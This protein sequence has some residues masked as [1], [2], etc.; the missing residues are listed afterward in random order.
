MSEV[1]DT[2]DFKSW[3]IVQLMGHVKYAGHAEA[4]TLFGRS[5]IY[6]TVPQLTDSEGSLVKEGFVKIISPD[7]LY[8]ITPVTEA[9]AREMAKYLEK[10]PIEGYQHQFV[11]NTLVEQKLEAI[12]AKAAQ[13]VL[14]EAGF[15][16]KDL[17]KNPILR[18][19]EE[20]DWGTDRNPSKV[21]SEELGMASPHLDESGTFINEELEHIHNTS[22]EVELDFRKLKCVV[23]DGVKYLLI[24]Y[25][26]FQRVPL[27]NAVVRRADEDY[28]QHHSKDIKEMKVEY[29]NPAIEPAIE[30]FNVDF[31]V[32]ARHR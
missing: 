28:I 8:D 17:M 11:V 19:D 9:Y 7:A 16:K 27:R 4:K 15:D 32:T 26:E 21:F 2:N 22:G 14:P 3:A 6:L 23:E 12:A 20:L 13:R 29:V 24:N 30:V 1:T 31:Q 25:E 18:K 10:E 5:L